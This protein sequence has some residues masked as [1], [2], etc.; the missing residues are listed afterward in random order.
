[1]DTEALKEGLEKITGQIVKLQS[2]FNS[3]FDDLSERVC[4]LEKV[5]KGN[6]VQNGQ[7][8]EDDEV[9]IRYFSDINEKQNDV[10]PKPKI[11]KGADAP[12]EPLASTTSQSL[13]WE[14]EALRD[15]VSKRRLP[16]KL[17]MN[18]SKAGIATKDREHAA[19]IIESGKFVETTI[20]CLL[21]AQ[22]NW[23]QW[24]NVA[25][26]LDDVLLSCQAHMRYLQEEH[27]TLYVGGQYGPQTKAIF[28]SLQRNTTNLQP[29]D[30]EGLKVA[31]SIAPTSSQNTQQNPQ[32]RGGFRQQNLRFRGGF[33]GGFRGRG[34]RERDL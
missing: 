1:M 12:G 5:Q 26:K 34:Y 28:R 33:R 13:K 30:V 16:P 32:Q 3:R 2:D 11:N 25:D 10:V 24:P 20:K 29:S 6:V 21:E 27:N 14:Y 9:S 19:V 22:G 15:T 8:D 23:G 7:E 18:D 17:R 4:G 31:V